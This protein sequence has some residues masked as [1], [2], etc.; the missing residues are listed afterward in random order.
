MNLTRKPGSQYR[1]DLIDISVAR[2]PGN[3]SG[4]SQT[5]TSHSKEFQSRSVLR[6]KT[7]LKMSS[8]EA[9]DELRLELAIEFVSRQQRFQA[10]PG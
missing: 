3:P 5:E 10:F 2:D 6:A 1:S 8:G 7:P 4:S 9:G